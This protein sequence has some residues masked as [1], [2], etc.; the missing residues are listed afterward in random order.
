ML[1]FWGGRGGC[2][3]GF[4]SVRWFYGI[5]LD[6]GKVCGQYWFGFTRVGYSGVD[7]RQFR[8]CVLCSSLVRRDWGQQR[9]WGVG[10]V[11]F[12]EEGGIYYGGIFFV[13][14]FFL[15]FFLFGVNLLFYIFFILRGCFYIVVMLC[16]YI[17]K[18]LYINGIFYNI[19]VKWI[20][21]VELRLKYVRFNICC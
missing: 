1:L 11:W 17:V 19:V 15:L 7:V 16:I 14:I 21:E 6:E 8:F 9:G 13:V 12:A 18:I 20:Q 3:S 5:F 4:F 2:G 10:Y